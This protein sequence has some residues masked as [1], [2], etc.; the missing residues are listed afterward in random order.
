MC[1]PQGTGHGPL[2]CGLDTHIPSFFRLAPIGLDLAFEFDGHGIAEAVFCRAGHNAHPALRDAIFINIV[3]VLA[4][5]NNAD[6]ALQNGL[7]IKRAVG[8]GAQAV[9]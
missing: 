8:I 2:C 6:T 4:I 3:L 1:K 5:K 7:V 9:W